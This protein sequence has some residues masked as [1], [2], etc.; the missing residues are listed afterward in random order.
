MSHLPVMLQFSMCKRRD[1]I[2]ILFIILRETINSL[3]FALIQKCLWD[4]LL[5]LLPLK[6][7]GMNTVL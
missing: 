3:I 6:D 1:V 2:V 7:G 5:T 4:P